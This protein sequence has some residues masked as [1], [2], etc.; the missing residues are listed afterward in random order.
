MERTPRGPKGERGPGRH[1]RGKALQRP[2]DGTPDA[3]DAR[4]PPLS[5]IQARLKKLSRRR[6]AWIPPQLFKLVDKAPSGDNWPPR[7]VERGR[8][9]RQGAALLVPLV[10]DS[11]AASKTGHSAA[12]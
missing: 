6:R 11:Q 5:D 4:E 12:W 7:T 10:H 1:D 3:P 2:F 9:W 8:V